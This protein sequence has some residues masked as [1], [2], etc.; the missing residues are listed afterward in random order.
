MKTFYLS[1][2]NS[3]EISKMSRKFET[4]MKDPMMFDAFLADHSM[5]MP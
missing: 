4:E 3:K 2:K 1:K 5:N